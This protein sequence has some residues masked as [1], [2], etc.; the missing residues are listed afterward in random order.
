MVAMVNSPKR[1]RPREI[2]CC[3]VGPVMNLDSSLTTHPVT[4]LETA[5]FLR[6]RYFL[7]RAIL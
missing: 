5:F 6:A 3:P 7:G 4:G 1:I 2:N